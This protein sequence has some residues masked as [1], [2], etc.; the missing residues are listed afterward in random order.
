MG[1]RSKTHALKIWMNGILVGTWTVKPSGQCEFVYASNWLGSPSARSL[2][3]SMPL[4][5][6]AYKDDL[7]SAF[8]DNL[9]PDSDQIR[10]RIQSR[11][12]TASSSPFDLLT[13][14]GRDCVGAIQLL[15]EGQDPGDVRRI[16]GVPVDENKVEQLLDDAVSLGRHDDEDFRISIAGAQEK[17]ALL[18]YRG[19]WL[20]PH[21]STPTTHIFKLPIGQAGQTGIDMTT[22]VENEW[23]CTQIIRAYGIPVANCEMMQFGG[24]KALVVERFDRKFSQDGSWIMRLPQEDF[25]QATGT[26]PGKKY[27]NDGGPG[28][29]R[30]MTILL[31]SQNPETDR[32]DFFRTQIAF[33]LLCGIDGHAKN[34]S[35]FIEAGGSYRMTPRYDV[36][37]AYPVLGHG[38]NKL[39]PNKVRM[40]MA[41]FGKNRHYQWEEISP[42]HFIQTG[43]HCGLGESSAS[44]VRSMA[45][46][47]PKVIQDVMAS[48]PSDFPESVGETIL[49]GLSLSA[50]RLHDVKH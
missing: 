49:D 5:S 10:R 48:L 41:V 13:E 28:I 6:E 38:P 44:I 32:E 8:F 15:P 27:E 34:F 26:P 39:S 33:W 3:L 1:R 14:I 25:C 19:Q 43:T 50:Q 12:G 45:E 23:L 24:R 36:L 31:G 37:S 17:T 7:V 29:S 9:L 4:R 20:K 30:I 22:S 42:R 16:N 47:T 40:A 18:K 11:F 21:G 2:S 46:A 35:L